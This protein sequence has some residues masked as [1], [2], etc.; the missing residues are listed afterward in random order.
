MQVHIID[1]HTEQQV[2]QLK[3]EVRKMI[4]SSTDNYSQIY[5]LIDTIQRLGV[6]YHFESEIEEALKHLSDYYHVSCEEDDDDLC[7][8]ALR[9]RLLRQH[10]YNISYGKSFLSFIFSKRNTLL[11][12]IHRTWVLTQSRQ[13]IF[14]SI[15]EYMHLYFNYEQYIQVRV[16]LP[17][18]NSGHVLHFLSSRCF[19]KVQ[20]QQGELQ[21]IPH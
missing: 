14:R 7:T 16:V 3:E 8:V 21:G 20:G 10:G 6:S 9:F 12:Y 19:Q 5:N 11:P 13:A 17:T 15:D 4:I 2:Q 1:A 18:N